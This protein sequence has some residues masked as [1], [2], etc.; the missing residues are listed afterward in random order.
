MY[1]QSARYYDALYSFR[2]YHQASVLVR[3]FIQRRHPA[4]R[5]LLDVACGTGRHLED[6]QK[7]FDVEGLD[8]S[9]ELLETASRRCPGIPLHQADMAGF[10]IG[11]K[12]DVVTCFFSSIGYLKTAARMQDAVRSMSNHLNPGGLLLVEPWFTPEQYRVKDLKANFVDQPD[13]KIAWMYVSAVE[14]TVSVMDIHYLVGKLDGFE[15]F[16]ERHELGL[17]TE[18]EYRQAFEHSG[19][20][21]SYEPSGWFGR[22]MYIGLDQSAAAGGQE[23]EPAQ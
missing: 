19:L 7:Y 12:F 5:R 23:Q 11:R 22:G 3:Q 9:S 10:Q 4:A 8:L 17:F 2:D 21:V 13:L 1:T 20:R 6:L 16:T 14:G 15:S 18:A